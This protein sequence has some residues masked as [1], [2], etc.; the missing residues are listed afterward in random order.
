[1]KVVLNTTTL[2]Q[3]VVV[4]K[5]CIFITAYEVYISN[6]PTFTASTYNIDVKCK[7][8]YGSSNK[9]MT[10][11]ITPNTDPVITGMPV[12]VAVV[13][14]ETAVQ[15]LHTIAITDAESQTIT[16]TLVSVPPG[17]FSINQNPA[18]PCKF[19]LP[20]FRFPPFNSVLLTFQQM[21]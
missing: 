15:T 11:T 4:N 9:S 16:C 13:E 5:K 17:P 3:V 6:N 21:F 12:T 20:C 8:D 14:T 1:L 10:L 18:T 7:D 19:L 2:T